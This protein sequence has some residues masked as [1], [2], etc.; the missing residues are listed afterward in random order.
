MKFVAD[1]EIQRRSWN[2]APIMEFRA[3]GPEFHDQQRTS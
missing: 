3:A 2:F 1:Q